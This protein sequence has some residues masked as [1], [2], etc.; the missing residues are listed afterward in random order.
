MSTDPAVKSVTKY[1]LATGRILG[2]GIVGFDS[3]PQDGQGW[4]AGHTGGLR[5][6]YY[7]IAEDV[8]RYRAALGASLSAT[9]ITLGASVTLAPLPIPCTVHVGGV[10]E[11]V[12]VEDGSLE[13]TPA[14]IGEAY[15]LLVD[16]VQFLRTDYFF[17]VVD[18]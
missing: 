14:S 2:I 3:F 7:D 10:A 17:S 5:E 9:S 4:L 11:P 15:R 6:Q 1:D 18:P 8:I 16:E 13:V 12:I